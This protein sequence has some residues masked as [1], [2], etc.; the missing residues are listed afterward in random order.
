[1]ANPL[2]IAHHL[3]WTAY[4]HW[5]PNDP[6]GSGSNVIRSDLLAELGEIHYGRKSI[7][8]LSKD[9]D[10][11]YRQAKQ[12]LRFPVL[13]FGQVETAIIAQAF[14]ELIHDRPYTCYACAIM[15]DHVHLLIRKHKDL[16]EEMIDNFKKRSCLSLGANGFGGDGHPIW[17]RGGWKV[18]LDLPDDI[19]R[20]TRYIERNPIVEGLPAQIYDFVTEYDGWPLHPGQNPN[21]HLARRLRLSAPR[22]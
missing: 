6:R 10:D 9:I 11:F 12:V 2:V 15:P 21:S 18:F 4:G 14:S 19:R 17:T 5:L 20:T 7:Q 22:S 16:A 3:I 13:E 1:M 8:P